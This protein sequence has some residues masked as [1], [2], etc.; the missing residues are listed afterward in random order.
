M[1]TLFVKFGVVGT[2][3]FTIAFRR[4]D[5]FGS[6]TGNTVAQMIGI[7]AFVGQNSPGFE[8]VDKIMGKGDVIALTG[9]GDQADRQT[10]RLRRGMDFRRQSTA[11]P[12][13]TLGIRPPFD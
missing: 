3:D 1:I 11:R 6:G 8:A 9:G 5:D 4:D 12:T 10:Q 7:V 2:L 13:Q